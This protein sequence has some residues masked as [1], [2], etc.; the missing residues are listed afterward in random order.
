MSNNLNLVETDGKVYVIKDDDGHRYG[1]YLVEEIA[2]AR[3]AKVREEGKKCF[4]P[5]EWYEDYFGMSTYT[6][7]DGPYGDE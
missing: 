4:L 5:E 7:G 6:L 1:A 3:L 2:L